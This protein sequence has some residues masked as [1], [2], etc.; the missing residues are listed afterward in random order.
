MSEFPNPFQKT[1]EASQPVGFSA[2]NSF[3]ELRKE[4][5]T[6]Y[7]VGPLYVHIG[8]PDSLA[9]RF[10]A[11][12]KQKRNIVPMGSELTFDKEVITDCEEWNH[13]LDAMDDK[14]F[15]IFKGWLCSL[16]FVRKENGQYF[17]VKHYQAPI[18]D[19]I[20]NVTETYLDVFC[21]DGVDFSMRPAKLS[22]IPGTAPKVISFVR[23]DGQT[24]LAA[25]GKAALETL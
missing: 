14:S 20:D 13:M 22:L 11:E 10:A 6:P 9:V 16:R 7:A 5:F 3:A 19:P 25:E 2:I 1:S 12:L 23:L 24:G 17:S 8:I 18:V 21:P 15:G 4:G